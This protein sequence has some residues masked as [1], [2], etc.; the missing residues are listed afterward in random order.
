MPVNKCKHSFVGTSD[1]VK[2][3]DCGLLLTPEQYKKHMQKNEMQGKK[4][5]AK[6]E[7]LIK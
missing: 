5:Q 1:G 4:K 2:C 7:E 3:V 6:G